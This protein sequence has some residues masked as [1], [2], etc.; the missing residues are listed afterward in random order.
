[1]MNEK[2]LTKAEEKKKEEIVKAMKKDFKGPKPALYAIATKKAIDIAELKFPSLKQTLVDLLTDQYDLFIT[3]IQWVAPKPTTFR[4]ILGN[5]ELFYLIYTPRT[6]IAKIEGKKYY[7]LNIS[8]G[9]SA[10]EALSR[11]LSYGMKQGEKSPEELAGE[12]PEVS[13]E[14][15]PAP[16]ETPKKGEEEAPAI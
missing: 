4:L 15:M 12:A 6:W 5:G 8:E 16:E 11:V 2:K 14:E 7:L 10:T 13:P 1:M 9:E 3:D